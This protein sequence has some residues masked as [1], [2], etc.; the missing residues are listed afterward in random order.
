MRN[1]PLTR[2][3]HCARC[4]A[5]G[6]AFKRRTLENHL[7]LC[8]I[9]LFVRPDRQRE[10]LRIVDATFG[11][12]G[13]VSPRPGIL[14]IRSVFPDTSNSNL[15]VIFSSAPNRDLDFRVT[16]GDLGLSSGFGVVH[17]VL[18]NLRRTREHNIFR[19]GV[20][21]RTIVLAP[22]GRTGL[23]GFS[24]SHVDSQNV[25]V[26]RRVMR[27]L[28]RCTTCRTFRYCRSPSRTD[29][30]S[31]L[32]STN[33][34]FCRVVAKGQTFGNIRSLCRVRKGLPRSIVRL[35][36]RLGPNVSR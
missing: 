29:P 31:S 35:C 36:P 34:I 7:H 1:S 32:F 12:I 18:R 17:S 16:G 11:T 30:R 25:A 4:R 3:D 5:I 33:L 21:P 15:I 6:S 8:G 14:K 27:R 22:A 19:E 13:G 20:A 2:G 28:R 9:S 10:Q 26:T 23:A 24:F